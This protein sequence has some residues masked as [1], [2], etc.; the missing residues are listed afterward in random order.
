LP[1]SASLVSSFFST[2]AVESD[3]VVDSGSVV[4]SDAAGGT[5]TVAA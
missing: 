3:G 2:P 4:F 1:V 5:A